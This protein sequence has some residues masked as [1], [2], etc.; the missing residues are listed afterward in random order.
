MTELK[1][2]IENVNPAVLWGPNNDHF[3]IIKKQYP[4]LKLVA[5]GSELKVL[6][7]DHELSVFDEKFSH[8]LNH[9]EKFEN[10]NIT[11][12]ERILGS[13]ASPDTAPKPTVD[14]K[15]T[16]GEVLVFGPNGILVKARTANQK[17]M[18]TAINTN[19]ILFAI[20]PAGTGKTYTAVALAVR[21]LKNKEVKRIILTRPAVEAGENLGFLP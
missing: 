20:G 5:R 9:V 15:S 7:D 2:S 3:E 11:D 8:L 4:K 10:L 21:A 14:D 12:L 19:D 1:I 18:V 17:R 6:G 13:K 16:T